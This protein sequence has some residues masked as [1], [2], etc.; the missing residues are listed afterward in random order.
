MWCAIAYHAHACT[1]MHILAHTCTYIAHACPGWRQQVLEFRHDWCA[2][3]VRA[4]LAEDSGVGVGGLGRA[5]AH[6]C[7][8]HRHRRAT[9]MPLDNHFSRCELVMTMAA[10]GWLLCFACCSAWRCMHRGFACIPASV[11]AVTH[12][13]AGQGACMRRTIW[14]I[15]PN[16]WPWSPMSAVRPQPGVVPDPVCLC[17]AGDV[18]HIFDLPTD[19]ATVL[20]MDK[21]V[22]R[23]GKSWQLQDRTKTGSS[24]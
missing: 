22:R 15:H 14:R 20:D 4:E 8:H 19:F 16:R 17:I 9:L 13:T 10:S 6:R 5:A 23:C 1:H 11:H 3:Q 2:P 12:C 7:R 18:R 21:R 24:N